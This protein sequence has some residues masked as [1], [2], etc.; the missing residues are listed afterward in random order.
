[1]IKEILKLL[2]SL[3]Q[4]PLPPKKVKSSHLLLELV[5]KKKESNDKVHPRIH[6]LPVYS[7]DG[8]NLTIG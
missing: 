1:M 3:L 6:P 4:S 2:P 8:Q 5:R 7:M